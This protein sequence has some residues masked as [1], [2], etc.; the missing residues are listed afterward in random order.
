M[1]SPRMDTLLRAN[2]GLKPPLLALF[3][4]VGVIFLVP[5]LKLGNEEVGRE[6]ARLA[7]PTRVRGLDL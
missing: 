1:D 7:I 2:G 4:A 3:R 5:K 6:L